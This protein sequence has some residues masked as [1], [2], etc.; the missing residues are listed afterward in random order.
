[1]VTAPKNPKTKLAQL[2]TAI[3]VRIGDSGG[4]APTATD[5]YVNVILLS[6]EHGSGGRNLDRASFQIDIAS[7]GIYLVDWQVEEKMN[8]QVEVYA[9]DDEGDLV[10]LFWGEFDQQ[11]IE[12][13][14]TERVVVTASVSKHHFGSPIDGPEEYDKVTDA[15]IIVQ[16]DVVFNPEIRGTIYGNRRSDPNANSFDYIFI[17][18]YSAWTATSKLYT[19]TPDSWDLKTAIEKVVLLTNGAAPA[20]IDNPDN[21]DIFADAPVLKNF[22]IKR[23]MYL[24]EAL[25][26]LLLPHGFTW[27][28]KLSLDSDD[29]LTKEIAFLKQGVGVE[30]QVYFQRP[31]EDLDIAKSNAPE[32]TV[33]T[34]LSELANKV[35]VYGDFIRKEATL[36]LKKGWAAAQDALTPDELQKK[37]ESGS[38]F[39]TYPNVH[40]KWVYNE[41]GDYN[42]LRT[43]TGS[44]PADLTVFGAGEDYVHKRRTIDDQLL[45][46]DNETNY[47]DPYLEYY[48]NSLAAWK[49]VPPEWGWEVLPDEI[50]IYF[51][52][53]KP[54]SELWEQGSTDIADMKLRLTCVI[55]CDTRISYTATRQTTSPIGR[56]IELYINASD[57]FFDKQVDSGSTFFGV[58]DA[59]EQD[60]TTAIQTYA[61]A[62]RDINDS[63]NIQAA[64]VIEG[65]VN[66]Y[67]RGDLITKVDGRNISLNRNSITSSTKKYPQVMGIV[68]D[69]QAQRTTL[70]T[71]SYG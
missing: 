8:R 5:E 1:M 70:V 60:D 64:I 53:N 12:I 55:A 27:F 71:E 41:G 34:S 7:A 4:N 37:D 62:L 67:K 10:P 65:I 28:V 66:S 47:R 25:D 17:D 6:L 20:F 13:V 51:N 38:Q 52:G 39:E 45:T 61:E 11:N 36:E 56:D 31:G 3:V 69:Y 33:Q 19:A 68:F 43:E 59:L 26:E 9:I 15:N 42:D 35:T 30:K 54:P 32:V 21:Y 49:P 50:G 48:D 44:A 14:D 16:K 23:G 40:R 46:L 22:T 2:Y 18:P 63:A 57:R 29:A 58:Y 24:H